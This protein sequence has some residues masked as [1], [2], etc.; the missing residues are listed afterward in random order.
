MSALKR[1]GAVA[2][3]AA[4]LAVSGITVPSAAA[5]GGVLVRNQ[6]SLKCLEISTG[7]LAKGT[8]AVQWTCTGNQHQLWRVNDLNNGYVQLQVEHS[9]Q[10]LEVDNASLA[11]GAGV[12]QWP[13][14]GGVHQQWKKIAVGD[15]FQF[16]ARHSSQCL[17]VDQAADDGFG[18]GDRVLQWPCHGDYQQQWRLG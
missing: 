4:S 12:L 2:I 14:H 6:R 10:C 8:K 1:H 15:R 3:M 11:P 16:K 5:D 18:N 17:E 9:G 7:S 13:C